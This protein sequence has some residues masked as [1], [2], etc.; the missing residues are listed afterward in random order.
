[1]PPK[2]VA[3]RVDEA[4]LV[5]ATGAR[6]GGKS[7]ESSGNNEENQR[8]WMVAA[9]YEQLRA[10][11]AAYQ[12]RTTAE[13]ERLVAMG[14]RLSAGTDIIKETIR[15]LSDAEAKVATN[16]DVLSAKNYELT[17][18]IAKLKNEPEVK[19]DE[20][21]VGSGVIYNQLIN[22]V[23]EEH[24]LDDTLYYL[25][26]ALNSERIELSV[27]LKNARVLARE[28]FFKR[29]LMNKIRATLQ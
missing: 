8:L 23:A 21:L 3:A 26:K 4:L 1:M 2:G 22:V 6:G 11:D 14:R 28:L 17:D 20:I 9:A 25:G 24:A 12:S 16:I 7:S 10:M 19:V 13:M 29:A 27:F 18:L 15:R 5:G